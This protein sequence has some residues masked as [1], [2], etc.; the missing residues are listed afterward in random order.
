MTVIVEPLHVPED[1]VELTAIRAQ[2]AGGQNVNKVSSAIHLRFDIMA[3]SLPD[4]VKERLLA[5]HDSRIT[6]DGVLVLK[7][8]QHRTQEMNRFDALIRLHELVNSVAQP[9]KTRKPTKPTRASVR[10]VRQAKTQ[11]SEVKA[12][13][14]PV[15][16]EH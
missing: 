2:G 12:A 1:E 14:A 8:Q 10:R 3:S 13:R 7:A 15:R 16:S 4:D 11:R 6:R 5:L 9:P